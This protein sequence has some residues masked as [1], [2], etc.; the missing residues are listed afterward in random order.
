MLL[1][2]CRRLA[3]PPQEAVTFTHN[4]AGIAAGRA[5]GLTVI[6]IGDGPHQE[7]LRGFGAERVVPSLSVL[8]DPRLHDHTS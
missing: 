6:G 7:V 8:L 5:A 2:A 4:P 1:A 3:V